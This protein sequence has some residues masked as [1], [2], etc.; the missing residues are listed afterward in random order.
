ML[1]ALLIV[2]YVLGLLIAMFI[3]LEIGRR[4]SARR[5][6]KEPEGMRPG[7]TAM[8]GA[9]FGLLGLLLAFTFGGAVSRFDWR[10]QLVIQE[11]NN[12]GTGYLRL[13]L[14]P[15][16]AQPALRESFRRYVDM[17]LEVYRKLP[18][19]AAAYKELARA[20]ELQR[21]IWRAAVAASRSPRASP[22][23]AGLLLPALNAMIE[24]TTTRTFAALTHPP[25]V[26]F[27]LLFGLAILSAFLAGFGLA[28]SKERSWVH[29]ASFALVLA[30]A[31]YVILDIEY[32]RVGLIKV[33]AFDKALIDLRNSMK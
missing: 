17:R 15:A 13:D 26:V 28:G 32:P 30:A 3:L 16:S 8:D 12:I 24:I 29:M 33:D 23:V 18:D 5:H 19:V 4:A 6:A 9:V 1:Y 7:I 10:R 27:V 14:L 20:D 11:T 22:T 2:M 21:E 31:V 25:V